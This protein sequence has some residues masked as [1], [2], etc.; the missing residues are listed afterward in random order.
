MRHYCSEACA[1]ELPLDELGPPR[2][3]ALTRTAR[4]LATLLVSAAALGSVSMWPAFEPELPVAAAPPLADAAP[5]PDG[6]VAFGPNWPPTDEEW[7]GVIA[8]DVWVHPLPGPSRRMPIR[9][10]RVFGAERHGDRPIECGHGH[11]GVD[12]GGEVWGEPVLAAHDGVVEKVQRNPSHPRGGMYVRLAH[13]DGTV[14]TQ[15]FHLA[16]IP[17]HIDRGARVAAGDVI[18]LVGDT[19]VENSGAHLHFTISVRPAPEATEHHMDPEPLIAIWPLA[20][21]ERGG[22]EYVV[23]TRTSPGVPRGPSLRR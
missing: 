9:D 22:A 18:G 5:P 16:A 1:A 13:R 2:A 23:S 3:G 21:P 12:I 10:S 20:L 11:C 19:G 7:M 8:D 15:Y 17:R 6:A 14:F 4:V